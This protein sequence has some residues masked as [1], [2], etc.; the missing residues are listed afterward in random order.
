MKSASE[1]LSKNKKR[2]KLNRSFFA[3]SLDAINSIAGLE[4]PLAALIAYVVICGGIDNSKCTIGS[5]FK[6]STHAERSISERSKILK[7][8]DIQNS[9][10]KLCGKNYIFDK[11]PKNIKFSPGS[12]TFE[13]PEEKNQ[14]Y[15]NISGEFLNK[16]SNRGLKDNNINKLAE[17]LDA[18]RA[19]HDICA[20]S[21][22]QARLDALVLFL[23]L[24]KI[25]DFSKYSGV[26]PRVF[27]ERMH[28]CTDS[29]IFEEFSFCPEIDE[30]DDWSIV[31]S[32]YKKCDYSDLNEMSKLL[33]NVWRYEDTD[34]TLLQRCH[35]AFLILK[36]SKLI[37]YSYVLWNFDP[38]VNL[39]KRITGDEVISCIYV[40]SP[41][42]I[43]S[44]AYAINEMDNVLVTSGALASSDFWKHDRDDG[45]HKFLF[46]NSNVYR[47]MIPKKFLNSWCLLRQIRVRCWSSAQNEIVGIN[48]DRKRT[49]SYI[50]DIQRHFLGD[51][52]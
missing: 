45:K 41:S 20:I 29:E 15:L 9:I 17:L 42:N 7:H 30:E 13:I 37:Y 24:L 8:S 4:E 22:S 18:C 34:A 12:I 43:N 50:S 38:L 44:E 40:S 3:I 27:S 19:T 31:F 21:L 39:M 35:H 32:R 26:N 25:Q 16:I 46:A 11:R 28:H 49:E 1:N 23:N 52:D 2:S 33:E 6:V 47:Y 10:E 14:N 36:K 48:D 5:G 51:D